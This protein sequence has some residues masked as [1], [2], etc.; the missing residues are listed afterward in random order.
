MKEETTVSLAAADNTDDEVS[1][2]AAAFYFFLIR[3]GQHFLDKRRRKI[4][5]Q[6]RLRVGLVYQGWWGA[7]WTSFQSFSMCSAPQKAERYRLFIHFLKI[8]PTIYS[9]LPLKPYSSALAK[10]TANDQK[11]PH[12]VT[13]LTR[14]HRVK[15]SGWNFWSGRGWA[16]AEFFRRSRDILTLGRKIPRT[17][18]PWCRALATVVTLWK[19][20]SCSS[21]SLFVCLHL[22]VSSCILSSHSGYLHVLSQYSQKNFLKSQLHWGVHLKDL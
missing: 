15:L 1:A 10:Q 13:L 14:R 18:S 16:R 20:S 6:K 7:S 19:H 9:W 22:T 3:T 2:D 12:R 8:P 4:R 11:S 17:L 21:L 5:R